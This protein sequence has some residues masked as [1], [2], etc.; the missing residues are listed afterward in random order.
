MDEADP[1]LA[2]VAQFAALL[3]E[4]DLMMRGLRRFADGE[5]QPGSGYASTVPR[6]PRACYM[7]SLM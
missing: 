7:P 4:R 6:S 1:S 3:A 2:D 5:Q